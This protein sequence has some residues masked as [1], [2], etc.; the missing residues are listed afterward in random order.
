MNLVT[1]AFTVCI[2]VGSFLLFMIQPMVGKI[3]L[4]Y[5]GGVPA[6]WTTCMLFFQLALLTGYLYAEKSIRYLG[7]QRQSILH[8]LL[9]TGAFILLPLHIDTTGAELATARPT[10]WLLARL[11]S[12]IGF[13]FFMTAANA[14]LL[15]RYYS[16]T[17]QSDSGDPYFLYAA[18]NLGS[19]LALL[20]YPFLFEPLL[21]LSQQRM[22]WSGIFLV[23]TVLVM[24][25]CI[26]LWHARPTKEEKPATTERQSR[27]TEADFDNV[28]DF[29]NRLTEEERQ[30]KQRKLDPTRPTWKKALYWCLLGFVPC[31]AM[32]SVTTH[33]ATDIASVPLLWVLPLSMYLI[34]FIMVFARTDYWRAI[35]WERYLFPAILL[36]LLFYHLRITDHIWF[37]IP[38][39]LLVMFMLSIYFHG[40]LAEDRPPVLQLNSYFV[41]MST[42]GI[43]G[44]I[45]N[46]LLAPIL[47][48]TQLEYAF[49]LL[50]AACLCSYFSGSYYDLNYS[51]ARRLL[52]AGVFMFLL[53]LPGW[54]KETNLSKLLDEN[55]MFMTFMALATL[56]VFNNF[57]RSAWA[58]L[59]CISLATLFQA[60]ADPKIVMIDRSF[61]GI[62]RVT[63]LANDG[64]VV[65]PDLKVEGVKDIFYCLS[66]GTTLHGVERKIDDMRMSYPLSYYAREGPVGSVFRVGNI[67]RNFK[68]I[69][70]V[71]LGCGTL[72]WYGR[73]WQHF[74]FF[75]IDQK[76]V[77]IARNPEYFTFLKNSQAS[78]RQIVG[79]ARVSL[80][81]VPDQ[82]YDLLIL[83]AYSSDAVPVHLM[84]L[85]AFKLYHAKVKPDG[86]LLF[87][88]SNRHFKL[89]PVIKRNCDELGL[90][91]L[92]SFDEPARYSTRYDWYDYDQINRA[93][94][95][96]AGNPKH[97]AALKLYAKWDD[98]EA[99]AGYSLWTDDYANLL[100]I[101][102]W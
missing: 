57:R 34:S 28:D 41:W 20:A 100:Q 46:G 72:A 43:L 16:E 61:F 84:T 21:R 40:R 3:L 92:R 50:V 86:L 44:G 90:S 89:A 36:A 22:L 30:E 94:W 97:L 19:L 79:D 10:F 35:R 77:E 101:Y 31:S 91:C 51:I 75:E 65:D 93:D 83:D 62:L 95:V 29:V 63:R 7:C 96:A 70:V 15:Q 64:E 6:V 45:F 39:H 4:P 1:V 76:V 12:S 26:I 69:G 52:V 74:D 13:L 11:T 78:I 25:C 55:G 81:S 32:L 80:Q 67:N 59:L 8:L 102:M 66:H 5:L 14:P 88:I 17:G 27:V 99:S 2:F 71:G 73:P 49:T 38:V 9:L 37:T 56:Y 47:F 68:N 48:T 24:F 87:H 58:L 82:S 23:Q 54:L 18:S 33:I 53:F 42:G 60:L 98:M 85:E